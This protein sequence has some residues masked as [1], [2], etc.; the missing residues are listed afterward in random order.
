M[1]LA[2]SNHVDLERK[3]LSSTASTP[4]YQPNGRVDGEEVKCPE[5]PMRQR[6]SAVS[7]FRV[8]LWVNS[9]FICAQRIF[10]DIMK[11]LSV[12]VN[13]SGTE[14]L[15]SCARSIPVIKDEYHSNR[16]RT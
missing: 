11:T 16:E 13:H 8:M 10:D 5:M 1:A 9:T 12:I 2:A 15:A 7:T 14:E 6:S 4:K 3:H